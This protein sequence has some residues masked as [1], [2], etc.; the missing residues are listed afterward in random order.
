MHRLCSVTYPQFNGQ[1]EL[2][3]K[4]TKRIMKGN[5]G[6]QGSLDND[7][8]AQAI[9][10]Y[11]NTPILSIGLSQAQLLL[12]YWLW[13]LIP[14]QPILYKPHSKW[15]AMAQHHKEILHHCNVKIVER[16]N[17][18]T[19]NLPPL[20]AGD[21]IAIQSPLNHRWN[22]MVKIITPLPDC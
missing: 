3:E 8:V 21:T 10:Q 14:S 11:Q 15:V 7:N 12:R 17:K 18:Y 2:T 5:T 19:H 22:T 6:P 16:Y 9:L 13:D 4:T 1:A 20:Q